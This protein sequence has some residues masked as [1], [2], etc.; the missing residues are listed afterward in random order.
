MILLNYKEIVAP[1]IMIHPICLV[2]NLF[3]MLDRL[4]SA[5]IIWSTEGIA[6]GP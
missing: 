1:Q 3:D 4:I 2:K 5:D 6:Q